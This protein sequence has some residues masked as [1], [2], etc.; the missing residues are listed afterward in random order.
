M[1]LA[2]G[3]RNIGGPFFYDKLLAIEGDEDE[4]VE[5]EKGSYYALLATEGEG[6]EDEEEERR[7]SYYALLLCDYFET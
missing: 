2:P 3:R 6:E 4:E 7:A 5:E 1:D